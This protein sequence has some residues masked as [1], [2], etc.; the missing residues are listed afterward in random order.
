MKKKV[1]DF[2][3]G[4]R[5]LHQTVC[6]NVFKGILVLWIM[7]MWIIIQVSSLFV[8]G[9]LIWSKQ[10]TVIGQRGAAWCWKV[11]GRL[12]GSVQA[13]QVWQRSAE[14][15]WGQRLHPDFALTDQTFIDLADLTD[16]TLMRFYIFD[17]ST[18]LVGIIWH[19]L[20]RIMLLLWFLVSL[21]N[22]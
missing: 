9:L 10:T 21:K 1:P 20:P 16:P 13:N 18:F 12:Q 5:L 15:K 3:C 4:L 2:Q 7:W 8:A 11:R 17:V 19:N 14:V 6:Q 22:L